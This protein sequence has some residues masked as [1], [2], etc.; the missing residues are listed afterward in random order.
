MPRGAGKTRLALEVEVRT[1]PS[2]RPS[3]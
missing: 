2:T 3:A 1:S